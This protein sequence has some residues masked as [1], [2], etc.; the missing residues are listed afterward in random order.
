[1][2]ARQ[3]LNSINV[4]GAVVAGGIVGVL[5]GSWLVF[6]VTAGALFSAALYAGG[7]RPGGRRR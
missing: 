2:G 3:K 1:V 5:T 6:F 4:A 7:I